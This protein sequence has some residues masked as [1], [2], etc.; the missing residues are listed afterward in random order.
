M[1]G[2]DGS[3]PDLCD[4]CYWRKRAETLKDKLS[5]VLEI[6]EVNTADIKGQY[7]AGHGDRSRQSMIDMYDNELA[8]I[9]RAKELL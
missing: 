1:H 8:T 7:I 2:R 6:A 9:A 3:D 4:V 5:A